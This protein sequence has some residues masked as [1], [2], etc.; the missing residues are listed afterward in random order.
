M[1]EMAPPEVRAA[2]IA[3]REAQA[4][5]RSQK[6]E[7]EKDR[8]GNL[9]NYRIAGGCVV[10]GALIAASVA[11]IIH[12]DKPRPTNDVNSASPK[13]LSAGAPDA[14]TQQTIAD[15]AGALVKRD[16]DNA[17]LR[18]EIKELRD[19]LAKS[20][21]DDAAEAKKDKEIVALR[22]A[23]AKVN[24]LAKQNEDLVAAIAKLKKEIGKLHKEILDLKPKK[25]PPNVV[26]EPIDPPSGL[27]KILESEAPTPT[28]PKPKASVSEPAEHDRDKPAKK[29][30]KKPANL[31]RVRFLPRMSPAGLSRTI[32]LNAKHGAILERLLNKY[33][34]EYQV[35]APYG[36]DWPRIFQFNGWTKLHATAKEADTIVDMLGAACYILVD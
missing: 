12:F 23:N 16:A 22:D 9:R 21:K 30:E 26:K 1:K 36:P 25:T 28:V 8:R 6:T 14:V 3:A 32:E 29:L 11:L 34:I 15:L 33:E 31:V 4:D 19:A 17:C 24:A 35:N 2:R 20:E 10:A 27:P 13:S 5:R 7:K 18:K